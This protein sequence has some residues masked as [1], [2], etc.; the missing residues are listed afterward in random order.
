MEGGA[1][2]CF[3]FFCCCCVYSAPPP[4]PNHSTLEPTSTH[5]LLL[6]NASGH[7]GKL[8]H[9]FQ[10]AL[11]LNE[12]GLEQQEKQ[13]SSPC[14]SY[15]SLLALGICNDDPQLQTLRQSKRFGMKML[16]HCV[17]PGGSQVP[18]P[19][20]EQERDLDKQSWQALLWLH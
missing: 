2:L 3:L 16:N 9:L 12:Y 13:Y 7:S 10:A 18:Y 8:S 15:T 19:C 14:T 6:G 17:N 4:L 5:C 11:P 1:I 20:L